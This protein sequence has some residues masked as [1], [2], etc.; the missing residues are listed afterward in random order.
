[1]QMI[2]LVSVLMVLACIHVLA[3]LVCLAFEV[4]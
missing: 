2:R 4:V 3:D 1:M